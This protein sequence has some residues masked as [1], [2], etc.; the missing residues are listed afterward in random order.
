MARHKKTQTD[1]PSKT[2]MMSSDEFTLAMIEA[3][4]SNDVQSMINQ[5]I[6]YDKIGKIVAEEVGKNFKMLT[7]KLAQKDKEISDLKS[8]ICE[9]QNKYDDVEQYS[10][11]RN[12]R[13]DGVEE[14][15]GENTH[16]LVVDLCNNGMGLNPPI[17]LSDIDNSHRLPSRSDRSGPRSIIVKFTSYRA[18]KHVY[19][20]RT[21]LKDL[22]KKRHAH[23]GRGQPAAA[24]QRADAAAF[25]V[26]AAD[27][28]NTAPASSPADP[29]N[30]ARPGPPIWVNEDL[31]KGRGEICFQ[32]RDLKR[33]GKITDVWTFDC[34]VKIKDLNNRISNVDRISDLAKY[35]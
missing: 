19:A 9:L 20:G 5:A 16:E 33:K 18:R 1:S 7:D 23:A 22:N 15:P 24:A 3:L 11:K 31:S 28:A 17:S 4:K 14:I 8:Q 12:L 30:W 35:V 32:A 6:D 26:A 27:P 34:K 10:R 25:D 21:R 2:T 13:I 29:R